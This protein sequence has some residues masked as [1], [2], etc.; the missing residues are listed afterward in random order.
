MYFSINRGKIMSNIG[1]LKRN[2]H[3]TYLKFHN[4]HTPVCLKLCTK[5]TL[6]KHA[7]KSSIFIFYS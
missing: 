4:Y 3:V 7:L 6:T 1:I 5:Q 2:D